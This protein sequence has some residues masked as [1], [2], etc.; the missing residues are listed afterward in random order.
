MAG[1][2]FSRRA[3]TL[4]GT[5]EVSHGRKKR[6]WRAAMARNSFGIRDVLARSLVA[7]NSSQDFRGEHVLRKRRGRARSDF[8]TPDLRKQQTS[9][10][11]LRIAVLRNHLEFTRF[12]E[13][14]RNIWEHALLS[15]RI[16][17][18]ARFPEFPGISQ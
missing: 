14:C 12:P 16:K 13:L 11:L 17:T 5:A 7:L 3:R 15:Q 8:A 4:G 6:S 2:L 1:V 9:K 18:R 10:I